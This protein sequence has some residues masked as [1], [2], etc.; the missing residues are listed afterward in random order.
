MSRITLCVV[1]VNMFIEKSSCLFELFVCAG[2]EEGYKGSP[3]DCPFPLGVGQIC[4]T[5]LVPWCPGEWDPISSNAGVGAGAGVGASAC[6]GVGVGVGVKKLAI[7]GKDYF[8]EFCIFFS[9][10]LLTLA[11]LCV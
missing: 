3:P 5:A 10:N 6:V 9:I 1:N 4:P 7:I 8:L 11:Q 2:G